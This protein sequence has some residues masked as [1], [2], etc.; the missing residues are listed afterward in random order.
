M[1]DL[2]PASLYVPE[3]YLKAHEDQLIEF[4]DDF[5]GEGLGEYRPSIS[6]YGT[7]SDD[8]IVEFTSD[9]A[10]A[11]CFY[12][13]ED[14]LKNLKIPFDR[15]TSAYFEDPEERKSYRPEQGII[16]LYGETQTFPCSELRKILADLGDT[17]DMA[18]DMIRQKLDKEY[19]PQVKPLKEYAKPKATFRIYQFKSG[20]EYHHHRFTSTEDLEAFNICKVSDINV[21]MYDLVYTDVY[22]ENMSLEDIYRR[23]NVDR[24][25]DFKG[26]SLSVS[27]VIVVNPEKGKS[28]AYYVDDIGFTE[29]KGFFSKAKEKA[30]TVR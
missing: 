28:K 11:G 15:V 13:L 17:P 29:L 26:H 2:I 30:P 12:E 24:P 4:V 3:A 5:F 7:V 10:Y 25:A 23:F 8:G 22:K 14:K 20:D 9:S 16:T 1:S 18:L 21:S 27:D 19:D 6:D